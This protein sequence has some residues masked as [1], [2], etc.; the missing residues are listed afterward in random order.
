MYY[1]CAKYDMNLKYDFSIIELKK[2]YS[3]FN[4]L[5]R[6]QKI[7]SAHFKYIF[8]LIDSI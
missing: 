7:I 3:I 2:T 6:I 8:T 4:L 5:Y 1:F